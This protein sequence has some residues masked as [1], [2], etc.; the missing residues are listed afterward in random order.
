MSPQELASEIAR[1]GAILSL[2]DDERD[3]LVGHWEWVDEHRVLYIE[4]DGNSELVGHVLEFDRAKVL[5]ALGVEFY[6]PEG[7]LLAYLS[8]ILESVGDTRARQRDFDHWQSYSDG[9]R[10][11]I[12]KRKA[13]LLA[14]R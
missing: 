10:D 12:Q 9:F 11:F 4:A 13:E 3:L 6:D 8:P 14:P 7:R 2:L 5:H 1:G